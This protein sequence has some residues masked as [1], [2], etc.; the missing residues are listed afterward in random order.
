MPFGLCNVP[1]TFQCLMQNTL[2]ELNLTYCVIY[3]DDIIVF[4]HTEQ[5]HLECLCIFF[6]CFHEFNLKLKPFK[7]SF[8]W[9]EIVYLAHHKAAGKMCMQ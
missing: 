7:C 8:F 6:E 3:L 4:G 2:G 1:T 9:S 5:E